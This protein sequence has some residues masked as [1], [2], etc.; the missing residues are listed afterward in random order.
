VVVSY[1]KKPRASKTSEF[2]SGLFIYNAKSTTRGNAEVYMSEDPYLLIAVFGDNDTAKI[3]IDRNIIEIKATILEAIDPDLGVVDIVTRE[4]FMK[5]KV[6]NKKEEKYDN[7]D[8]QD[9]SCTF[10]C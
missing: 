2:Y 6:K 1:G 3:W 9:T 7:M 10:S 4:E 5:P 8:I